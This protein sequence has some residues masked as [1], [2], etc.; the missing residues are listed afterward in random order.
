MNIND[1]N[2]LCNALLTDFLDEKECTETARKFGVTPGSAIWN[3][4]TNRVINWLECKGDYQY[5][6]SENSQRLINR[7]MAAEG[8]VLGKDYS[9]TAEGGYMVTPELVEKLG[10]QLPAGEFERMKE[11]GMVKSIPLPDPFQQLDEHLGVPFFDNLLATMVIRIKAYTDEEAA[12]YMGAVYSGIIEAHPWATDLLRRIFL[13]TGDRRDA[14]I[15]ATHAIR[16][17]H[18][19]ALDTEKVFVSIWNDL[20][21]SMG[22][23]D[24]LMDVECDGEIIPTISIDGLKQ[25]DRV[26][27]GGDIRPALLAEKL[28]TV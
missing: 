20:L 5:M 11:L 15:A 3:K 4:A 12:F 24:C 26:W 28:R 21:H 13:V 2:E 17:N 16:G 27:H 7:T 25:L 14:I 9:R 19:T 10:A 23:G 1:L 18:D 22:R 6:S 8:A